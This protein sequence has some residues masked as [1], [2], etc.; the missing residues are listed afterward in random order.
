MFTWF[1]NIFKYIKECRKICKSVT[2][3]MQGSHHGA[4]LNFPFFFTIVYVLFVCI[5]VQN[6]LSIL[7]LMFIEEQL[8]FDMSIKFDNFLRT[9]L[10]I[11]EILGS[12]GIF[13]RM[14]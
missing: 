13:F 7:K 8:Y 2:M 1:S 5:F 9:N 4:L 10:V 11:I 14:T 12:A 3:A 6:L